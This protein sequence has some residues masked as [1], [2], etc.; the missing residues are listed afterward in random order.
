MINKL[1]KAAKLASECAAYAQ[2]IVKEGITT[3]DIDYLI[4]NFIIEHN[5]YPTPIGFMNFPK[6]VCTSVNEVL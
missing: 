1:R 6:S 2:T 3:E 5:A 4:H